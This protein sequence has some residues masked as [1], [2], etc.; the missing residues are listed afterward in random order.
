MRPGYFGTLGHMAKRRSS[1][2]IVRA[3]PVQRAP[4][5]VIRIQ[6]PRAVTRAP[7]KRRSSHRRRSHGGGAVTGGHVLGIGLGGAIIG[8]VEK[9]FGASIPQIPVLGRKG[10]L[11][12]A[13]YFMQRNRMGGALT[14]DACIAGAAICGYELGKDGKV[15]GYDVDGE[16][17]PN[18]SGVASQF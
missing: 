11:T 1:T 7:K 8:F 5:Q 6:T 16:A 9:A 12:L 14:R 10:T 3:F 17:V 18:V 15:S 13:A 4:A 2:Q